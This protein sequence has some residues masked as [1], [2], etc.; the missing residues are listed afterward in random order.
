[1]YGDEKL[2]LLSFQYDVWVVC[3]LGIIVENASSEIVV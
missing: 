1:M 2:G 3:E